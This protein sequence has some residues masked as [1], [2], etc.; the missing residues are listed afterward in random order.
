VTT[1][2]DR[3]EPSPPGGAAL[4]P[5]APIPPA[6]PGDQ[7]RIAIDTPTGRWEFGWN[8]AHGSL[9]ARHERRPSAEHADPARRPTPAGHATATHHLGTGPAEIPDPGRLEQR[10]G[11]PLP[12]VVHDLLH[13]DQRDRPTWT[14]RRWE[15]ADPELAEPL[16]AGTRPQPDSRVRLPGRPD[17]TYQQAM[18]ASVPLRAWEHDGYRVEIRRAE[19]FTDPDTGR[20]RHAITYRLTHHG[21]VVFSGND[22]D[23]PADTDPRGDDSIR[24]VVDLLCH[25]TPDTSLT[26]PQRAFLDAHADAIDAHTLGPDPPYPAGTRVAVE[27][28][29]G[30]LRIG[31]VVEPITTRDG[32]LLAYA[33][34]PEDADLPGHPWH[35]HPRHT[36]V[37]PPQQLTPTL[38]APTTDLPDPAPLLHAGPPA[39][40]HPTAP[41]ARPALPGIPAASDLEAG[42]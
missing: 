33:W 29:A 42:L 38:A 6:S 23:A 3:Q 12:D 30:S 7:P 25:P 16:P 8:P 24:A 18:R 34:R 40:D 2:P 35:G 28:P 9:H 31:T 22:I 14:T 10:L 36:L 32:E 15:L 39:A 37:S 17:T 13:A 19:E 5:T 21:Q 1:H 4:P 26:Q 41:G 20:P 27:D 11:F